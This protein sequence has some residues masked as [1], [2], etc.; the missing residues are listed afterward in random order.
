MQNTD[1]GFASY[2]IRRGPTVLELLNPAEVFDSIMVEYSYPECS[3]AVLK[4][5]VRFR[6]HIPSYRPSDVQTAIHRARDFVLNSQLADGSW[7]GSWAV[8]F[9][10]AIWNAL[11]ALAAVGETWH[12]CEG[13]RRACGW[14]LE[15]QMEDG[16]WGEHHTS[17]EL[18]EYVA[19]KTS[20]VVN[21]GWAVLALMNAGYPDKTPIERGV[22]VSLNFKSL[23]SQDQL[24]ICCLS[25]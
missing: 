14:L 4:S 6:H 11:E 24:L 21:T 8:C 23:H 3:S 17:C 15:R 19:H 25:L 9:T 18:K 2:E 10:Y 12:T 13:V 20:Q 5:F 16:G 22:K 7:Y 1:G